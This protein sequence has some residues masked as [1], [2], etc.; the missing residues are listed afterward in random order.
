MRIA[1]LCTAS[2][3]T[4]ITFELEPTYYSCKGVW[5]LNSEPQEAQL[6]SEGSHTYGNYARSS[7]LAGCVCIVM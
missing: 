4:Y 1:V 2:H 6:T 7:E 5:V 3:V